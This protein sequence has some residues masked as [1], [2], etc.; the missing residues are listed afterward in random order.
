MTTPNPSPAAV[1]LRGLVELEAKA[2]PA[3]WSASGYQ[4]LD[5]DGRWVAGDRHYQFIV[6]MRNAL[7]RLLAIATAAERQAACIKELEAL[8]V[9]IDMCCGNPGDESNIETWR[10]IPEQVERL[11][12]II[13]Q[14]VIDNSPLHKR[15]AELEAALKPFAV[16]FARLDDAEILTARINSNGATQARFFVGDFHRARAALRAKLSDP[17]PEAGGSNDA[18]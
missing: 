4:V 1:D 18:D 16:R 8:L 2:E 13:G 17:S 7:P 11:S 10:K 12:R 9:D 5:R 3:P 6:A 15:I 14:G